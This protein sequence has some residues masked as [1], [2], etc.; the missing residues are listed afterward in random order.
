MRPH[1]RGNPDLVP[2]LAH[3]RSYGLVSFSI[4]H[5]EPCWT[6]MN[7]SCVRTPDDGDRAACQPVAI[8]AARVIE[9]ARSW[10]PGAS[11]GRPGRSRRLAHDIA[12]M[13]P[14]SRSAKEP[15]VAPDPHIS[16]FAMGNVQV[17][18]SC[19]GLPSRSRDGQQ[20]PANPF[21]VPWS[22][23]SFARNRLGSVGMWRSLH[24][25]DAGLARRS[26]GGDDAGS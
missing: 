25:E 21:A 14:S 1:A 4:E 26:R 3:G 9:E 11:L 5:S 7:D 10:T 24:D 22:A 17:A 18:W 6:V 2:D 12:C 23:R 19:A 15:P 13:A 20:P 16:P 8:A